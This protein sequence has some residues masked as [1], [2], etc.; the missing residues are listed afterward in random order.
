[1]GEFSAGEWVEE[2]VAQLEKAKNDLAFLQKLAIEPL[3][4]QD[5]KPSTVT[6][7]LAQIEQFIDL[8]RQTAIQDVILCVSDP[9]RRLELDK[10]RAEKLELGE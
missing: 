7:P 2:M 9:K 10:A 1:M 8:L 5:E 3:T 6:Q 4:S